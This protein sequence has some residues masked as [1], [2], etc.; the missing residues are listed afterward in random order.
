MFKTLSISIV[1]FVLIFL[2]SAALA[3]DLFGPDWAEEPGSQF[4]EWDTWEGFPGPMSPDGGHSIPLPGVPDVA[5]PWASTG[6]NDATLYPQMLDRDWVVQVEIDDDLIF[7]LDNYDIANEQ[8][9]VRVQIT[10]WS[11]AGTPGSPSGFNV[12]TD[13][14]GPVFFPAVEAESYYHTDGWVTKAYDFTLEPNPEWEDI[15]LKFNNYP[16]YVDQVVIDTWCVPEPA[17]L[18]LMLVG[19]LALLRRRK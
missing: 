10:Y 2:S 7:H 16:E 13:Q 12:W 3:D 5:P 9:L 4:W 19:S 18:G 8:K 17:T 11:Q 15:G 14:G 1:V 6:E